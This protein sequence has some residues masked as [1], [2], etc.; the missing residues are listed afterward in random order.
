MD[1][2]RLVVVGNGMVGH[3]LLEELV[4]RGA[5]SRFH[6]SVFG[7]EK[8]RAYDRVHLSAYFSHHTSEE[9]SLSRPGWYEQHGIE[10]FLGEPV[11]AIDRHAQ[12]VETASGRRQPYDLLVL[13]T[14]S[15]PWV[16]PI[17]GAS[18]HECFVYRTIDDL[19]A[20]REASRHS[21]SG[22]VIGGGLLGLEAA[23]ALKALGLDTHVVEFAPVLMAEQLDGPGGELLRRKIEAL[24]VS[25]HTGKNTRTIAHHQGKAGKHRLAFA[26]GSHLDVDLVVFSTGIRPQ[27]NLARYC[28][29]PLGSRGGIVIDE[30]CRTLDPK[31]FAI[32]ECAA[33]QDRFY[34]LVAPGY[35]MAQVVA[36]QLLGE[37][38]RF[39]GAD[40]SAK[41]KLLGVSVGSI[42]DAHGRTPGSRS[43]RYQDDGAGVYK[44]IVVD[45][46]GQ[47]LLGA[48]LV[49]DVED[50]GNLLQLCLNGLPLPEHPDSLILPAYSGDKP[51]LGVDALPAS[52]Q[53]CSCFD[54]SK[55]R[56]ADAVAGGCHTLAA[57]K[58][59]TRAGTGCGGCIPLITQVLNSELSKQGVEVKNHLCHHFA[60]SRQELFH[61]I[62]VGGLRS[63]EAVLAKHG[64]GYGC[65]VCKPAVGSILASCWNDYVLSPAL[66]GLQDSNDNFLGNLQRDGSYSVI[67]RMAGGEVTPAALLALAE[68][69]RD[70]QLYTK[71]TGA[72]RIGLFGARKEQLPAIWGRLAAAGFET[73]QAYAKALRM[74]KTCVGSTWCRFGVQDSVGL[75]VEL[76]HRYK[77][78]RSPHKLKFGVS[79]CTRECAEAQ[80]KDIGVI[81]TDKGWN[82][83]VGGNGGMKPRHA[84]LLAA[85]LDRA[86]LIQ[87]IDRLLMFY[88]RTA[89]KLQRTASW[90]EGLD[91]GLDYL[92]GV[93][94]DDRLGLC[95]ELEA[96]LAEIR[97]SYQCEWQ[98]TLADENAQQRF[99]HFINSPAADPL[100]Q[101]VAERQQHRPARPDER[102][103]QR[104]AT[105]ALASEE[106]V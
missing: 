56:I 87:T 92:R 79:G 53:I 84:D 22:V 70:Y 104:I 95:A 82:L 89:D 18:H 73:G 96:D 65:E 31:I 74:V 106:S 103:P 97:S 8:R 75:G 81:A 51:Q 59:E 66:T 29:L 19:K 62:R 49:G 40:L 67:P 1:K 15:Y 93:V 12:V 20:I 9:L 36:S 52:A 55:G 43:Y 13:A 72:Q 54:I 10:L 98:A 17:D 30:Q 25:V 44:K 42:G 11:R 85:D 102:D 80:G 3:R 4:E 5:A 33:W 61:L 71:V 76:E 46:S 88:I 27:D 90:L 21:A 99:A 45:E 57:L 47:R 37:Q 60:Y 101:L 64:Q 105:F 38:A 83:Y 39:E 100:I 50:Y 26:D 48:V 77:G 58:A 7:A 63:F 32:G 94:L 6:I 41:L 91:G 16:P 2:I 14:G 23:G 78:I 28:D 34:G 24:G 35:K 69:A 86:T 68:V